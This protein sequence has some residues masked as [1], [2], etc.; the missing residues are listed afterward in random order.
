MDRIILV[1]RSPLKTAI[2]EFNR[3]A[4][5][6]VKSFSSVSSFMNIA[7]RG[8]N[9]GYFSKLFIGLLKLFHKHTARYTKMKTPVLYI[10]Y[11][12]MAE[13]LLPNL[14]RITK[15][16]NM[17]SEN[18]EVLERSVCTILSENRIKQSLKRTYKVDLTKAARSL[19]HK[20]RAVKMV[21]NIDKLFKVS[22]RHELRTQEYISMIKG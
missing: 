5:S 19:I 7:K 9:G 16:M 8:D 21:R 3:R 22:G 12:D 11:E 4:K 1:I 2:A 20:T 17:G 18:E 10:S 15:F 13:N 6:K 14:L